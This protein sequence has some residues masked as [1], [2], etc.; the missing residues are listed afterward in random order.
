MFVLIFLLHVATPA[1]GLPAAERAI[2]L[3]FFEATAGASWKDHSGWGGPAG[4]ECEWVGVRCFQP[5]DSSSQHVSA[6]ELP[7]NG[8]RGSVPGELAHLPILMK[9]DLK[10]NDLTMPLPDPVMQRWN[11][12]FLDLDVGAAIKTVE[13]IRI[14]VY[15]NTL[16]S[17]EALILR[18]DGSAAYYRERCRQQHAKRP[19]TYCELRRAITSEFHRVAEFLQTND[20]FGDH[21][22]PLNKGIWIDVGTT[23]LSVRGS[24]G[25]RSLEIAPNGDDSLRVWSYENVVRGV[26]E[27]L[28]W[29]QP[30]SIEKCPWP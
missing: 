13:E 22:R 1:E 11:E 5:P 10:N 8:L 17:N 6:I 26:F 25:V 3:N 18:S 21:T 30:T 27:S 19:Q 4:S 24:E 16:C 23:M 28:E 7:N 15:T 14:T 12:G 9:L 20:F 29:S 2:L